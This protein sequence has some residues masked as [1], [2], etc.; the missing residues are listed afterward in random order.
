MTLKV[1]DVPREL[2]KAI[3]LKAVQS[4]ITIRELVLKH[5][6]EAVKGGRVSK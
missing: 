4:D 3:R 1:D 5:L 2:M 6:S